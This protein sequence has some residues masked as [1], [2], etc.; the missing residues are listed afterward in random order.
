MHTV[1]VHY[2]QRP[3][4][5]TLTRI[6]TITLTFKDSGIGDCGMTPVQTVMLLDLVS[7]VR[8]HGRAPAGMGKRG[9]LA[10]TWKIYRQD[11]LQLEHFGL[12]K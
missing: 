1:A 9:A 5:P 2:R 4:S 10:L 3:L 12:H 6:L 8:L 11:S 7:G